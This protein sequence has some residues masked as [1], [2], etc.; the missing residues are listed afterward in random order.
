VPFSSCD[1]RPRRSIVNRA[2]VCGTK[3]ERKKRVFPE[4]YALEVDLWM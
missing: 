1:A 4:N 3:Q 2:L